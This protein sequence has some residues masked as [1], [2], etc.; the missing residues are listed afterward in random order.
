MHTYTFHLHISA[1]SAFGNF[2][3]GLNA[4]KDENSISLYP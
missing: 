2:A 1:L 4:D 3:F